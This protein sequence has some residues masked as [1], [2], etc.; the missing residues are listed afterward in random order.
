MYLENSQSK[1]TSKNNE[2]QEK[3][4]LVVSRFRDSL[5]TSDNK[6]GFLFKVP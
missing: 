5:S 6:T 1:K 3:V 4:G 2:I